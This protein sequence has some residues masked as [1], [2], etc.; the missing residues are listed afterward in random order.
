[1]STNYFYKIKEV[2]TRDDKSLYG[3]RTTRNQG[4]VLAHLRHIHGSRLVKV[5]K[6]DVL[7]RKLTIFEV[8]NE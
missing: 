5:M 6:E 8:S 2:S 1:M 7:G 3:W 4:A